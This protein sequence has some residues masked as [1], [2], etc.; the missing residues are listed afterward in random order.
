MTDDFLPRPPTEEELA[1]ARQDLAQFKRDLAAAEGGPR[2]PLT[3][4]G[5]FTGPIGLDD[6]G[7]LQAP[8]SL[9]EEAHIAEVRRRAVE[10]DRDG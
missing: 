10:D 7:N 3:S 1:D 2:P 6:E 4:P 9:E 8:L 5:K